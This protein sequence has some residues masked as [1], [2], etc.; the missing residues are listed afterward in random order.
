MARIVT[1]SGDMDATVMAGESP[2]RS[3]GNSLRE[4]LDTPQTAEW[5]GGISPAD[6]VPH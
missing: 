6:L 2:G 1:G 5:L 3:R 4:L